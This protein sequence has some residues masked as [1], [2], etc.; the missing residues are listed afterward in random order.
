MKL[1]SF[2]PNWRSCRVFCGYL[3]NSVVGT[4]FLSVILQSVSLVIH[5]L[6]VCKYVSDSS[7]FK[8]HSMLISFL[9]TQAGTL[10]R[11]IFSSA[12]KY[13]VHTNSN[14]GGTDSSTQIVLKYMRATH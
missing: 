10:Q 6:C 7:F 9:Q 3:I 5:E 8:I 4:M 14:F 12:S 13:N 11:P 2:C 1:A